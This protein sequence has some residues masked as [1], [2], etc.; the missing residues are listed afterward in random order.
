MDTYL[1]IDKNNQTIT[2][3]FSTHTFQITENGQ[4]VTNEYVASD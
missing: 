3:K 1:I 2:F 4:I